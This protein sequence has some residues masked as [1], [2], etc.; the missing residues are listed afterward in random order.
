[1]IKWLGCAT[2][3]WT[4]SCP[5]MT[6]GWSASSL[7]ATTAEE[8]SS[9][10][11]R[12]T[13]SGTSWVRTPGHNFISKMLILI[14]LLFNLR[15][16]YLKYH[17]WQISWVPLRTNGPIGLGWPSSMIVKLSSGQMQ[18]PWL[19][20]TGEMENP[21]ILMTATRAALRCMPILLALDGMTNSA[22]T[23]YNSSARRG[24]Q[25]TATLRYPTQNVCHIICDQSRRWSGLFVAL[26]S[27]TFQLV[28]YCSTYFNHKIVLSVI[29]GFSIS[30]LIINM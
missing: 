15:T 26:H 11:T 4:P 12:L 14:C 8:T 23:P 19:S 10:S 3:L 2:W 16:Q 17:L 6:P 25:N 30:L 24:P 7:P 27:L 13:S 29:V 21:T 22:M 9:R 20:H 18:P 5:G 1:M 28:G